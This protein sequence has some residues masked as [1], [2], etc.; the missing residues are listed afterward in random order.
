MYGPQ[1]YDRLISFNKL[2]ETQVADGGFTLSPILIAADVPCR[3]SWSGGQEV[4]QSEQRTATQNIVFAIRYPYSFSVIEK[5]QV[6]FE[7]KTGNIINVIENPK[8]GRR[9][10]LLI[11]ATFKDNS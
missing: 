7:G 2:T 6:V 3:T 8:A 5:M 1:I 11:T 10:E 9:V 4:F